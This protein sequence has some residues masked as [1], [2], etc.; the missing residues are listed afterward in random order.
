MLLQ[1]Y[2]PALSLAHGV[3]ASSYARSYNH[4][5]RSGRE[6]S[7]PQIEIL[8]VSGQ[9]MMPG[10]ENNNNNNTVT[11]LDQANNNATN[12]TAELDPYARREAELEAARIEFSTYGYWED[13]EGCPSLQPKCEDCGGLMVLY[14]RDVLNPSPRCSGVSLSLFLFYLVETGIVDLN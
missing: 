7:S 10:Q 11:T 3:V 9:A 4:M 5:L 2:I 13:P 14:H 1:F 6:Y 8:A 12:D